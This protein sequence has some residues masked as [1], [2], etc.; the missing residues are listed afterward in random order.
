[1]NWYL[2]VAKPGNSTVMIRIKSLDGALVHGSDSVEAIKR[3][4]VCK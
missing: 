2:K 4:I 1:M 3:K